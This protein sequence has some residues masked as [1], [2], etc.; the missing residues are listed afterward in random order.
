MKR[1]KLIIALVL[2]LSMIFSTTTLYAAADSVNTT[3][4][5][6]HTNDTHARVS[7]D[8]KTI[9]GF[10]GI[11]NIVKDLKVKNPNTLL[12]DAGDTFHGQSFATLEQGSSIVSIMN[13]MNYDLMVPGNHDF[14]YGQARLLELK[15]LAKFPI[16]SAN[17]MKSDGS[18]LLDGTYIK[19]IGG[20]KVGFFGITTPETAYKTNPK[21]VEGL[22][23]ADVITTSKAKVAELKLKADVIVAVTHVGTDP[24]S[25]VTSDMIAKAVT[26]IDLIIDG[27][28][29]TVYETGYVV[30]GTTIVSTGSYDANLGVVDL[31]ITA[32]KVSKVTARLINTTTALTYGEDTVIKD[33]IATVKAGQSSVLSQVVGSTTVA[34][35]GLR[36]H[37]RTGETNMGNLITSAMLKLTGADVAITN[38]GGIRDSINVGEITKNEILTVLPFGNYIITKEV[39]GAD[40]V[41]AIEM[42]TGSYPASAGMFPHLGNVTYTLDQNKAKGQRV[43]DVKI[44]GQP[45]VLTKTYILAT[46]DFMAVGGDGYT[47]FKDK[48]TVNEYIGLDEAVI[49]YVSDKK[50]PIPTVTSYATVVPYIDPAILQDIPAYNPVLVVTTTPAVITAPTTTTSGPITVVTPTPETTTYVVIS[51]DVLW[52]IAEKYHT[53]WQE[54]QKLN[55]IKNANL[56]VIGQKLIVPTTK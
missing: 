33:L 7:T 42:G 17:I 12:V 4:T 31:T 9:I 1:F 18:T 26:G 55:G 53:T 25:E 14:N 2:S 54:L 21:N 30:N 28:S 24:A 47:M 45:V 39:T 5:I 35:D 52:K 51:G 32:G 11:S 40:I 23:F 8:S 15:A 29:H 10:A 56:I 48:K 3:I 6:A 38:G 49:Q 37:V 13:A 16:I 44:K 34:L 50:N 46:N 22:T 27:H 20:I 43:S 19:E 36:D 41:A